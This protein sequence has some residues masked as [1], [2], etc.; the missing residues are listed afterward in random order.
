MIRVVVEVPEIDVAA[1]VRGDV[2]IEQAIAIV[3]EPDRAV[4]VHPAAQ[5]GLL[6]DVLEVLAV[7]VPEQR[8]I[9]VAVDEQV[10][11]AVVVDVAPD[12]AHRHAF[13]GPI[14]VGDARARARR[15]RRCR[16]RLLR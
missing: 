13:A 5:A 12:G 8:Q 11:A 14:Q 4:A 9:A 7:D 15:P 16:R 10:L 1:E 3:V 2:E 6:G